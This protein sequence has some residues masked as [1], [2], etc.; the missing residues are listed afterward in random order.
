MRIDNETQYDTRTL[1]SLVRLVRDFHIPRPAIKAWRARAKNLVIEVRYHRPDY[2]AWQVNSDKISLWLPP[3]GEKAVGKSVAD[4]LA[5][6]ASLYDARG[7]SVE[8][9]AEALYKALRTFY[10]L[11][12]RRNMAVVFK[13]FDNVVEAVG[14]THLPIHE[15]PV[16]EKPKGDAL[17]RKR[18]ERVLELEES[19]NKKMSRAK[20]R[21][22]T[23]RRQRKY[24]EKALGLTEN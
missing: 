20:T 11:S 15:L 3:H 10:R 1:G 24:Y 22:Q 13:Q 5:G 7:A 6:R 18:Y 23:L 9:I 16:V 8:Y 21:L 2:C 12:V 17:K 14:M 19:W 4:R